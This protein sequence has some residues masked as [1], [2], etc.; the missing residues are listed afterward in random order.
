MPSPAIEMAN[1]YE[2]Q[3][4]VRAHVEWSRAW[5]ENFSIKILRYVFLNS[6]IHNIVLYKLLWPRTWCEDSRF[7][8]RKWWDLES[9]L[10][11]TANEIP[12]DH[13]LYSF[14]KLINNS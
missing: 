13:F 12:F 14:L 11:Q 2:I 8:A 7:L 10:Q 3:A 4:R 9:R 5:F 6:F 1:G